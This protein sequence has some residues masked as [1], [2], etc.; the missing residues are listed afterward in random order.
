[1]EI[2]F[3]AESLHLRFKEE[4]DSNSKEPRTLGSEVV[5]SPPKET[6]KDMCGIF[7]TVI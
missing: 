7:L 3:D 1:M 2:N 4:R 6:T 5:F